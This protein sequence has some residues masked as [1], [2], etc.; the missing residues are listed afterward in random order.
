MNYEYIPGLVFCAGYV[1]YVFE[2]SKKGDDGPA[3]AILAFS[4]WLVVDL[5]QVVS[6]V[7]LGVSA[8]IPGAAAIGSAALLIAAFMRGRYTVS[9]DR[10]SQ[11]SLALAIGTMMVWGGAL[12]F[13]DGDSRTLALLVLVCSLIAGLLPVVPLWQALVANPRTQGT[14]PWFPWLLGTVLE[15]WLLQYKAGVLPQEYLLPWA[16]F[17]MTFFSALLR[18]VPVQQYISKKPA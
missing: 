11:S 2:L 12:V 8:M 17:L 9:T 1:L 18:F 7:E 4:I 14:L 13:Y 5:L 10:W 15:V 3:P 6:A 16:Y